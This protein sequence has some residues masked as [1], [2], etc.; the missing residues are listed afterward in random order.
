ME[1]LSW[2][3]RPF[4]N[5]FERIRASDPSQLYKFYVPEGSLTIIVDGI[6][7][8]ANGHEVEKLSTTAIC[9]SKC[10]HGL[11]RF[12]SFTNIEE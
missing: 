1:Q 8:S 2:I 10:L 11:V 7:H 5:A 12:N 3:S 9:T 4:I 6:A